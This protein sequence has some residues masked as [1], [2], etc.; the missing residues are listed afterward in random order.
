MRSQ[1]RRDFVCRTIPAALAAGSALALGPFRNA[2]AAQLPAATRSYT[3]GK[4]ALE[5]DGQFAGWL[6]TAAGGQAV[7]SV[8]TGSPTSNEVQKKSV[9]GVKYQDIDLTCGTG[10][11]P[12][13]YEWIRSSL[14]KPFLRRNGS[15]VACDFNDR[16]VT[17]VDWFNSFISEIVFPACDAASRAPGSLKLKLT[18]EVTRWMKAGRTALPGAPSRSAKNEVWLPANFRLRIDGLDCSRVTNIEPITSKSALIRSVISAT[19]AL[20]AAPSAVQVRSLVVTLLETQAAEFVQWRKDSAIRGNT[21]SDPGR[22]GQL[23]YLA[24]GNGQS[25]FSL[26]F[27][28]LGINQLRPEIASAGSEQIRR[29]KAEMFY[30]DLRFAYGAG[31]SA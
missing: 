8:V 23:D 24:P 12:S 26:S 22:R 14:E 7:T 11:S 29:V 19:P 6:Q 4:F 9:A 18:P 27:S 28:G 5:I 1:S 16:A 13:F 3:S 10:M 21:G 20:I 15:L 31:A 25:L 17:E 30:K 2:L